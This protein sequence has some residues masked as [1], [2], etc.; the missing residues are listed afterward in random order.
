MPE[1]VLL[2]SSRV[3]LIEEPKVQTSFFDD[4]Q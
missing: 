3:V 2:E 4:I 1:P